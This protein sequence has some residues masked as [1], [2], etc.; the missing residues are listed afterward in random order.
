M[1]RDASIATKS[2]C[3]KRLTKV[4]RE[5]V[6]CEG[7]IATKAPNV[8]LSFSS[9]NEDLHANAITKKKISSLCKYSKCVF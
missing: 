8:A 6:S 4:L 5:I 7:S 3:H 2:Y 9:F 1:M